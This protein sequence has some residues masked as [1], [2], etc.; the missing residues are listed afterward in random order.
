MRPTD[1][2]AAVA[3]L[4]EGDLDQIVLSQKSLENDTGAPVA[5]DDDARRRGR[6]TV[7]H[8][9]ADAAH[10]RWSVPNGSPSRGDQRLGGLRIDAEPLHPQRDPLACVG[11]ER[12]TDRD[13]RGDLRP[14][15]VALLVAL[16]GLRDLVGEVRRLHRCA[17]PRGRAATRP[18]QF[19]R[20]RMLSRD[21]IP[22]LARGST[23][24]P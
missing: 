2:A 21:R 22:T 16:S 13:A 10:G 6:R 9:V 24:E 5:D 7:Q 19:Q 4:E 8:V 11:G 23:I 1:R 14:L 3:G 17:S 15:G 18:P 12:A 20:A